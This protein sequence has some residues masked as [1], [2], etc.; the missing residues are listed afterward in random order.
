MSEEKFCKDCI[1]F[2]YPAG[3]CQRPKSLRPTL[4]YGK[5]KYF[6]RSAYYERSFIGSCGGAAKYYEPLY[7]PSAPPARP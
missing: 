6:D 7:A 1:W 3:R 2:Y 4:V 5:L